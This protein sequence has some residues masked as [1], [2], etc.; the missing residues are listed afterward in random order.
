[1]AVNVLPQA[2]HLPLT[3]VRPCFASGIKEGFAG[4]WSIFFTEC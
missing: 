2:E 3:M 4:L 1:M